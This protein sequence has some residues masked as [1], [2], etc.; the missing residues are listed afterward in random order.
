MVG[1][2]RVVRNW[3]RGMGGYEVIV[4]DVVVRV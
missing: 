4:S 3:V 2:V 1:G